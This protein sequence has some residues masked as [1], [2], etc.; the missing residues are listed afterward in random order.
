[1]LLVQ[2]PFKELLKWN[3]WDKQI[4]NTIYSY[5]MVIFLKKLFKLPF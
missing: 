1:M 3:D 4:T 5:E 2:H